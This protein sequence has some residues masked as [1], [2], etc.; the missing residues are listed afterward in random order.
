MILEV[1]ESGF[2]YSLSLQSACYNR[3]IANLDVKLLK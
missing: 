2:C 1:W 3:P